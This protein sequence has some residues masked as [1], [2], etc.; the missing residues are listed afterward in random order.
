MAYNVNFLKGTLEAYRQLAVKDVN[1]FYY[2]DEKDLYL[3]EAKLT[4]AED[5]NAAI[6]R[7]STNEADIATLK[8]RVDS[9][10]GG[11]AGGGGS[12]NEELTNLVNMLNARV[13]TV[14][15]NLQKET[16]RATAAEGGLSTSL[17][18]LISRVNDLSS[19]VE[20]NKTSV[21]SQLEDLTTRVSSAEE[22]INKHSAAID[23]AMSKA[24]TNEG[25][26]LGLEGSVQELDGILDTL[27]GTDTDKSVRAIAIEVLVEQLLA[28]GN[29]ENFETLQQ[30]AAW[31]ADHPEE[32]AEMNLAIQQNSAAISS[33]QDSVNKHTT[34]IESL[35]ERLNSLSSEEGGLLSQAKEYTDSQIQIVNNA[36]NE[37]K[38]IT[39]KKLDSFTSSI[40]TNTEAIEAINNPSTGILAQAQVKINEFASTLGTA[41]YKNVED[42]DAAGSAAAALAQANQYTDQ[43]LSWGVI[44]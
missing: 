37:Y 38:T 36:L 17:E 39:D 35:Q 40:R 14:E 5:L 29:T 23:S 30:L 32:A 10:A 20:S 9:L 16:E 11:G 19:V 34:T 15:S 4:S 2:V 28:D 43:A 25:K 26:I 22:N 6:N 8:A 12:T 33:I 42:F 18:G 21:D 13:G 24:T 7:I 1:T 31:L 41:A 3:G 27:V 44:A